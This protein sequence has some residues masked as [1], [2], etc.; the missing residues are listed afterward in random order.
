MWL[1]LEAPAIDANPTGSANGPLSAACRPWET[2]RD[3]LHGCPGH[4]DRVE[5]GGL[6]DGQAQVAYSRVRS[7]MPVPSTVIRLAGRP[8]NSLASKPALHLALGGE[9]QC[10][11]SATVPV[12]TD[13]TVG[14]GT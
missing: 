10:F 7:F 11:R 3:Q 6:V 2:R 5:D 9:T 1:S 4:R 12:D 8:P 14:R 13:V